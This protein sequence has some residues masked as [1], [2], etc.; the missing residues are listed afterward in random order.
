ML[1][2]LAALMVAPVLAAEEIRSFDSAVTLAAD[3][4]VDVVET[5]TVNAEGTQIRHGIYR[6]IPTELTDYAKVQATSDLKV[7]AMTMD[8]AAEPIRMRLKPPGRSRTTY[9]SAAPSMV[10]AI[11]L[12][13][14]VACT[15]A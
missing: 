3:G 4:S 7:I 11:T 2:A 15:L 6:D 8:G 10:I 14:E 5:I 9:G 12:R 13:S 1:A